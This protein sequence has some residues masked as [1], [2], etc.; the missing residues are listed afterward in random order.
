MTMFSMKPKL[1]LVA[2]LA[3][4]NSRVATKPNFSRSKPRAAKKADAPVAG[5]EAKAAPAASGKADK[6]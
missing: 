3:E 4:S 5:T 2:F 1:D 6:A